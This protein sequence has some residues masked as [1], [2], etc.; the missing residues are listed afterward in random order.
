MSDDKITAA[1]RSIEAEWDP[2]SGR[3]IVTLWM[4][5][6]DELCD[7][8]NRL[9]ALVQQIAAWDNHTHDAEDGQDCCPTCLVQRAAQ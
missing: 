4:T 9:R 1:I 5:D 6:R 2:H 7:E 8:L 3:H